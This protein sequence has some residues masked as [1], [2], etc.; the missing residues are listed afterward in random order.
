MKMVAVYAKGGVGLADS[1]ASNSTNAAH[2]S[3]YRLAHVYYFRGTVF[4][5]FE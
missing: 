2:A 4:F 3:N 5:A 1:V